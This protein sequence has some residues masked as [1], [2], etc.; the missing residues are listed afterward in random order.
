MIN[1]FWLSES[2]M[3]PPRALLPAAVGLKTEDFKKSAADGLAFVWSDDF[4]KAKDFL[5]TVNRELSRET[6]SSK[7]GASLKDEFNRHREWQA[8]KASVLSRLLIPVDRKGRIPLPRSPDVSLAL[9]EAITLPNGDFVISLRGLLGMIGAHEWRKKG[10]P[11]AALGASIHPYYGVF[12]PVRGEYLELIREAPLPAQPTTA[13]DIGTGT[14]VIVALLAKR[15]VGKIV[16]TDMDPRALACARENL[17]RLGY[18]KNAQVVEADLFPTGQADLLVCNPP[19]LPGKPTAP[20]ERAVYDEDSSMLRGFLQGAPAHLN[21]GGEAWL[22]IS[23]LAELIGLRAPDE[24]QS[25]IAQAGLKVLGRLTTRP[26]H[27]KATDTSDPLFAARSKEVT[28]LWRLG[29]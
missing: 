27:S 4:H 20:I 14:G 3:A 6:R 19:W 22:I 24:L 13:F 7:P 23:D 29:R 16:A 17:R 9:H 2:E 10:V 26:S 5:N 18:D 15:G 28:S 21:P 25:W 1:G 8:R 12:S 11:V